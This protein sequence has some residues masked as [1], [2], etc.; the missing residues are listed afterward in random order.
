MKT[1]TL[2]YLA[3]LLVLVGLDFVW[4]GRMADVLY[5]P[6]M[7][8]IALPGFRMAPAIAFYL[9]FAAGAVYFAVA[10]ALAGGGPG[11]AAATASISAIDVNLLRGR[12]LRLPRDTSA[13]SMARQPAASMTAG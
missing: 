13:A 5:R 8:E 9:A 4:L 10:P 11:A 3:T 7:G 1:H 6:V 12:S 2:S